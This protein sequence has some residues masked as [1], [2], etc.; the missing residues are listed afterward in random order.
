MRLCKF[1]R[2]EIKPAHMGRF[3]RHEHNKSVYCV[4]GKP[5]R[6]LPAWMLGDRP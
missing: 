3:W 1:C 2:R 4:I 6:A 5:T